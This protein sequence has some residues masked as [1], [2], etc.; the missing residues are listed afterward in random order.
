MTESENTKITYPLDVTWLQR[1]QKKL[2]RWLKKSLTTSPVRL[3]ILGG[4]TTSEVANYIELFLLDA[5]VNIDIYQSDYNQFYQEAMFDNEA[6]DTFNPQIIY[7]H[8]SSV[9]IPSWPEPVDSDS[10]V[11]DKIENT[12]KY[13]QSVWQSLHGKY[14][15]T[16]I[17]N[18][19]ELPFSRPLG[20]IDASVKVGKTHFIHAVNQKFAEFAETNTNFILHDLNYLSA[21][22]GLARWYDKTQWYAYKYAM[23]SDAFPELGHSISK[24]IMAVL[25]LSK[26]AL[27]CDLDNTLWG[28]V[29][30]DEGLNGIQIGHEGA[31][32]Q[33][34]TEVQQYLKSLH[35]RGIL[36]TVCSKNDTN[37]AQEG[38]SHPDS[39]L[40]LADFSEFQANWRN[41]DE[42][43][44]KIATSLNIGLDSLVFIDDNAIEREW[45][46]NNLHSV[47]VPNIGEDVTQ[48]ITALDKA[49]LFELVTL[50]AEDTSRAAMYTH[51]E[52]R[53]KLQRS[54]E[55][56]NDYLKSLDMH[57]TI[58]P[59]DNLSLA[60]IT[61]L[62]NK[63]NQF[64]LTT[65]RYSAQEITSFMHCPK[66]LCLYGRLSDKFGDNG[67]VSV[68][69]GTEHEKTLTIDLWLMSCRVFKRKME[70]AMFSEL[71]RHAKAR[72]INKLVGQYLPSKKNGLVREHYSALGFQR[73]S[74][75]TDGNIR[76]ILTL[77]NAQ[78]E[79]DL[80]ITIANEPLDTSNSPNA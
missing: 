79:H 76:W 66:H 73:F 40:S 17:Q 7:I 65:R 23:S 21:W 27:V 18:N 47:E 16:V 75:D 78:V 70:M 62:T 43:I 51:N 1:R 58:V 52:E 60:R 57:A 31:E 56:Y 10:Q 19:F 2:R 71:I 53:Q 46:S 68:I 72:N 14:S 37:N 13:F 69:I 32:A 11:N 12:F 64:N 4:S 9:N 33:A 80:P 50:S 39:I 22:F 36:L 15:A 48:Y 44:E 6:L 63:T 20:N 25:G 24:Q 8:T 3:A 42:N 5:G 26:K 61:Q 67:I 34:F 41:K 59:F 28:G 55:N 74:E 38:F 30:G 49:N 54:F 35:Q 45:V 29:I 77:N